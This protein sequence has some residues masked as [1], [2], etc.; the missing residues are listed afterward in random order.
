ISATPILIDTLDPRAFVDTVMTLSLTFGGIHLEDI[1][2]PDCY[3]IEDELKAR[4]DK[5]VMHDDQHGTATVALSAVINACTM[6]GV[7]LRRARV[8]QI[9]L[10]AAGGAIAKLMMTYGVGEVLVADK[11]DEAVERLVKEGARRADLAS[12]MGEADIVI[13]ATGR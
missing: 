8:G 13:S 10:G 1:R 6:T 11:S 4:L 12:V 9:G 2:I 3:V 7:E 5:P